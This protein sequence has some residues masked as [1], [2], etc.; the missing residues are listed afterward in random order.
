ML[1]TIKK[2]NTLDLLKE[3]SNNDLRN[4]VADLR[5]PVAISIIDD[6]LRILKPAYIFNL[7]MQRNSTCIGEVV[8]YVLKIINS[9]ERIANSPSVCKSI[10]HLCELL[11]IQV[12]K[13]FDYE[14][15]SD[16]YKVFVRIYL[17][18]Q[19]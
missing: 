17:L 14:I 13:R 3:Y 16:I 7:N 15:N 18:L 11:I 5:S 10:K 9:W 8:P 6:Y 19:I 4:P 2:A 1:K 12:R